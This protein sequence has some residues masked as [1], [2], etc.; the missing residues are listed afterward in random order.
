MSTVSANLPRPGA[1]PWRAIVRVLRSREHKHFL[2]HLLRLDSAS[3]S[4]RFGR[5]VSDDW[6]ARYAA[7]TNWRRGAVVGCW[8]DGTLRGVAELRRFGS[9]RSKTAEMALSIEPTFQNC[10]LG[11]LLAR[12]VVAIARTR[13]FIKL[14]MLIAFS[15][16]RM[17][18]IARKLGARMAFADGEID[19]DLP[20]DPYPQA[21]DIPRN[22][23][24]EGH[25]RSNLDAHSVGNR[26][27]SEL[28]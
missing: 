20:L 6:V 1:I 28:L 16:W 14:C 13:G 5:G 17:R 24:E 19:A 21:T 12:R 2:A 9:D 7:E 3:R 27:I 25:P 11:S 15:N 22:E 8:I 18:S 26:L 4:A 10:G 23:V